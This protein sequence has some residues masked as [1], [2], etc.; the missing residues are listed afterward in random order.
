MEIHQL[1]SLI[2]AAPNHSNQSRVTVSYLDQINHLSFFSNDTHSHGGLEYSKSLTVHMAILQFI[3]I[4]IEHPLV[5]E[6]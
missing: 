6:S 3:N 1:L 2:N 4:Y 5:I